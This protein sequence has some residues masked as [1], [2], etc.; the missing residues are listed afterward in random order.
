MYSNSYLG[1]SLPSARRLRHND[2]RRRSCSNS[3]FSASLSCKILPSSPT[4]RVL[5]K[6]L[7]IRRR[8]SLNRPRLSYFLGRSILAS[9][10][11]RT[12]LYFQI[13]LQKPFSALKLIHRNQI[14]V[15]KII[16]PSSIITKTW[17]RLLNIRRF[18]CNR[19]RLRTHWLRLRYSCDKKFL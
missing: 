13:W 11:S 5:F 17:W 19:C 8:Y 2:Q 3:A 7:N 16:I 9:R 14:R 4:I 1:V 15:T 6:I 18:R 12:S 10:Y